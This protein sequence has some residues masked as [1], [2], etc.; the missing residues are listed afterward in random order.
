MIF[1]LISL[2]TGLLVGGYGHKY[3]AKITGAPANLSLSTASGA[4]KG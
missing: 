3:L 2:L 4:V 1:D